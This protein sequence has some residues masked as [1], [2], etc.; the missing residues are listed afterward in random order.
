AAPRVRARLDATATAPPAT[1]GLVAEADGHARHSHGVAPAT[2]SRSGLAQRRRPRPATLRTARVS[3][4]VGMNRR[5]FLRLALVSA[6]CTALPGSARLAPR[7]SA[8]RSALLN[9][10]PAE[11][12]SVAVT[13]LEDRIVLS[14]EVGDWLVW[15]QLAWSADGQRVVGPGYV[16]RLD[17]RDGLPLLVDDFRAPGSIND[18]RFGG[19]GAFGWHH[20]RAGRGVWDIHGR[21]DAARNGGFGVARA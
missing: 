14:N 3:E 12:A 17:R 7:V 21:L 20:A 10:P 6:G 15:K 1:R 4:F 2:R 19:L 16:A 8:P 9:P 11:P 5:V 18:P 13:E